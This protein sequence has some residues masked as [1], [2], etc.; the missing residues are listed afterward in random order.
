MKVEFT[1]GEFLATLPAASGESHGESSWT[2]YETFD[3]AL[4]KMTQ[5]DD[6]Y[7]TMADELLEKI[8]DVTEGVPQR[9]WS[10]SPYGAYPVVPEYLMD[11]PTPMR[12]LS[13]QGDVSPVKVVVSTTCSGGISKETMTARGTAILA[14]VMKLQQ[15]RPVELYLLA[16]GNHQGTKDLFVMIRVDTKPLSIAHACFAMANVGFARQLT[17]A[18]MTHYHGWTGGW[19]VNYRRGNYATIVRAECGIEPED[20][21]I[22]SSYLHDSELIYNP[23]QWVNS[24][25]KKYNQTEN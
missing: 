15:I 7:A 21:W 3:S 2:D 1:W 13:S 8:S 19:P 23:V 9:V 22:P 6:S 17:Y 14:L 16:E 18:W 24:Q 12:M 11:S 25:L 10:A 20:L 5:G 4:T